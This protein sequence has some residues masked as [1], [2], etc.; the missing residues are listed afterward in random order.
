MNCAYVIW[1]G[2]GRHRCTREAVKDGV[3]KQHH[4]DAIWARR[5]KSKIAA[6]ARMQRVND[7]L[8]QRRRSHPEFVMLKDALSDAQCVLK[9]VV[10][11]WTA[12]SI[13]DESL[14]HSTLRKVQMVMDKVK[15]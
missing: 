7:E 15:S 6:A 8:K 14:A 5:E 9:L 4:P 13:T 11:E 2:Y 1:S 3:C 12:P 10:D